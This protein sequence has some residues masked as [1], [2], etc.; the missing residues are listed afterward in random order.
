MSKLPVNEITLEGK[1]VRADYRKG[2][3]KNGKPFLSANFTLDIDGNQI[4]CESFAMQ[5]KADNVTETS[6]Y[7]GL[8]TI[9]SEAKAM[10]KTMREVGEDKSTEVQDNTI[11]ENIEEAT[12]IKCSNWN[13]FKYCKFSENS[14]MSNG[15]LVKNTK[16]EFAYCNRVDEDK[17]EYNPTRD[18]EV[19]G[20]VKIAPVVIEKDDV[21]FM[22]MTIIVPTYQEVYNDRPAKVTL[23]EI[24][25]VC[26][27]SSAWGYLEDNFEIGCV[28]YL[29]GKIVRAVERI[30]N[31][32]EVEDGRGFGRTMTR[33]KTYT[34]NINEYLEVLGGYTLEVD[35]VENMPEFSQELWEKAKEEKENKE[36]EMKQ[37][38]PSE[39]DR[40]FGRKQAPTQQTSQP[41]KNN[42]LPF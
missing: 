29:N 10:H 39:P 27:D 41:K 15:E 16:I 11:V 4:K 19:C 30:E 21:E 42:T 2:V 7:I 36:Q 25:L 31:E 32:V 9:F 28:V 23:Q 3:S 12:A 34:T 13:G 24:K 14:Y 8:N 20:L 26:H 17:R 6:N 18:F 5:Y 37:E 33:Q 40:T 35:E 22:Q 38:K 1:I